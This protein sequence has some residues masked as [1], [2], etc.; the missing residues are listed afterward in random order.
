MVCEALTRMR[1]ALSLY[2]EIFEDFYDNYAT[3]KEDYLAHYADDWSFLYIRLLQ[4]FGV[5]TTIYHFS[6]DTRRI[7]SHVH[8]PS[9]CA[10][11]FLPSTRLHRLLYY[12]CYYTYFSGEDGFLRRWLYP[13][14]SYVA[15]ISFRFVRLLQKDRPDLIL[16]QDYEMGKFDVVALI[17]KMLRIPLVAFFTGGN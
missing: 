6:R 7:E 10:V 1:M 17:A 12:L 15:P 3:S 5:D 9:G 11:K 2:S 4:P 8:K 14:I 13:I 16:Q